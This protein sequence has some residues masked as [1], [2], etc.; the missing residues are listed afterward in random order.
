MIKNEDELKVFKANKLIEARYNLSLNEQKLILYASSQVNNFTGEDF[1]ILRMHVSEFLKM[2]CLDEKSKNH[3]YIKSLAKGLMGKQLEVEYP[4]G[5][6]ELIQWVSR[7]KYESNNA[8]IEFEFS[9]AMKP[10]LLKLEKNYRGYP[11]KEVMQLNS[12]YS[13]RLYELLIQWEYTS[14]KS[15]NIKVEE[16]RRKMGL[17]SKEY[18]RFS[19]FENR[20]IRAAVTEL[21]NESNIIVTYEKIKKGRTIDEIQFKFT[22]KSNEITDAISSFERLKEAGLCKHIDEI[23]EYFNDKDLV[24]TD[25]ELDNAYTIVFN[26][27]LGVKLIEDNLQE[28]I[29]SYLLYYYEYTKEKAGKHAYNYFTECLEN[30]YANLKT[31]LKFSGDPNE[32]KYKH[33]NS[34]EK[35]DD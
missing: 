30:D 20:V 10:Y 28:S 35:I 33:K 34:E 14:H 23:K 31:I 5:D 24:F 11:L 8:I 27:L 7:C 25:Y 21:N 3:T 1:T 2:A 22:M 19:D 18:S 15:L 26:K 13:I 29:Y 9:S 6:W 12:K 4:N 16:L 32:I 17:T